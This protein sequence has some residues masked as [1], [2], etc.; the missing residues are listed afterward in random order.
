LRGE[1]NFLV[2]ALFFILENNTYYAFVPAL[3]GCF[4]WGESIDAVRI[5]IKDAIDVYLR[6]LKKDGEPIPEDNGI[7]VVE[8]IPVHV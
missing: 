2:I 4:T 3:P 1:N 8:S 7:E 5:L 6:S